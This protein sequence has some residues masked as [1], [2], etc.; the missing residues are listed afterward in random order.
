MKSLFLLAGAMFAQGSFAD[1]SGIVGKW[2]TIDDESKKPRSIVEI[3]PVG[4]IFEAKV[5]ELI[6]KEGDVPNPK[7]DKCQ[8]DLKDQPIEGLRILT[9]LKKRSSD[10]GDGKILDPNNGKLYDVKMQLEE[11]GSK[12]KVRGFIGF[13]LLGRT[14]TWERL[15]QP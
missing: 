12:L 9:D 10:W 6:R 5:V 8:G 7:C 3:Y 2:R 1:N 4:D 15:E 14:Q 11:G 13:S